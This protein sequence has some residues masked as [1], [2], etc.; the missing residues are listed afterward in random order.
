MTHPLRPGRWFDYVLWA[1]IMAA[2][3]SIL[4]LSSGCSLRPAAAIVPPAP[5]ASDGLGT[6]LLFG[7][8]AGIVCVAAG[9]AVTVWLP[10]KRTGLAVVAFG[11]SLVGMCLFVREVLPYIGWVVLAGAVIG[12]AALLWN[13]RKLLGATRTAWDAVPESAVIPDPKVEAFLNKVAG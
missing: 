13:Y 10:I 1:A 4:F 3:A 6:W 11:G 5:A 9:I 8:L 7:V 12:L 2:L